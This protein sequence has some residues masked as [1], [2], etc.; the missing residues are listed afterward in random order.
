MNFERMLARL[1]KE[2]RGID[3][4]ISALENLRAVESSEKRKGQAKPTKQ[5]P[6]AKNTRER[7]RKPAAPKQSPGETKVMGFPPAARRVG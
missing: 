4:A 6:R 2:R 5:R 3:A 7:Q 1:K